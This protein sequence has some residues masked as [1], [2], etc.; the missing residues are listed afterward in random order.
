MSREGAPSNKP[1]QQPPAG[2]PIFV[3]VVYGLGILAATII[4]FSVL[5]TLGARLSDDV[6]L[7]YDISWPATILWG[8]LALA[9][10]VTFVVRRKQHR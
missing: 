1:K 3:W 4:A 5:F 9:A 6:P 7:E 10:L 2:T 8:G